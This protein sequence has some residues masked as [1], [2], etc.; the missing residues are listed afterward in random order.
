MCLYLSTYKIS[1]HSVFK[2]NI[3]DVMNS[4][5]DSELVKGIMQ[6]KLLSVVGA[7][8]AGAD[9]ESPDVHGFSGFPL[10]MACALGHRE[11]V[12]ELLQ[13]GAQA[14]AANRDG[15]G[16]AFRLARRSEHNEIVTL[17]AQYEAR[18]MASNSNNSSES[19][20]LIEAPLFETPAQEPAPVLP[21]TEVE[22]LLITGCYGVDTSVLDGDLLRLSHSDIG[23]DSRAANKVPGGSER[24][25][26]NKR[27]FKFWKR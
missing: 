21:D 12:Q 5:A 6:G 4:K 23:V 25:V 19:S 24:E 16:G 26:E 20:L 11:I 8:E 18:T 7:L 27:K 9:I 2:Q 3:E 14:N 15:P 1:A 13:R 17:L 10:R 22:H